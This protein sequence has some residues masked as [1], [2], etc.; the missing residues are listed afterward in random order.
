MIVSFMAFEVAFGVL[1]HS[2]ALLSDAAHMLSD[3]VAIGLSIVALRLSRRP[4]GGQLTFGLRRAEILAAQ[5]NGATLLVLAL[6]IVYEGITRL[7]SPPDVSGSMVLVV[8]LVGIGVNL[9]ATPRG[10]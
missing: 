2:L 6:L 4:A 5:F 9:A 3:A 1:A 10:R 7:I 8:A